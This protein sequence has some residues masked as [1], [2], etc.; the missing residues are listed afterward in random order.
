MYNYEYHLGAYLLLHLLNYIFL[1]MI[2][3][4]NYCQSALG[5]YEPDY[6]QKLLHCSLSIFVSIHY[7]LLLEGLSWGGTLNP[8]LVPEFVF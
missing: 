1:I 7:M 2:I 8:I 4:Y 5:P 6:W 3:I